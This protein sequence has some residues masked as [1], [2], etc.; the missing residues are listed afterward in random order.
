[1]RELVLVILVVVSSGILFALLAGPPRGAPH[2]GLP[3]S[4]DGDEPVRLRPAA[5]HDDQAQPPLAA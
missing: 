1:M 4:L 2:A 5:R 3:F